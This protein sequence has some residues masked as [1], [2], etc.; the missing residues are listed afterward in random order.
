MFQSYTNQ[1]GSFVCEE[2]DRQSQ[3]NEE[4]LKDKVQSKF[5]T[6]INVHVCEIQHSMQHG[7]HCIHC[8]LV[9]MMYIVLYS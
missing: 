2:R 8:I 6:K 7:I 5:K 4:C 3:N 1:N 9:Y